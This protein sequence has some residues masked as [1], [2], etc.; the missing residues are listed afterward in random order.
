[1]EEW[2]RRYGRYLEKSL[3][4][5]RLRIEFNMNMKSEGVIAATSLSISAL[6]ADR[7]SS[8]LERS[9]SNL[10]MIDNM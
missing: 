10:F 6:S 5:K 8:F 9:A 1:M 2:K 4:Y 3:I 7:R